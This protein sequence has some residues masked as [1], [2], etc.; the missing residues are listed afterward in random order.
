M[1]GKTVDKDLTQRPWSRRIRIALPIV[2]NRMDNVK[3]A[4][5]KDQNSVGQKET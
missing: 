2:L 4:T 1:P 3:Y 5:A